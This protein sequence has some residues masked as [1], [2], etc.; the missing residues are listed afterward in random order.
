M[1]RSRGL[2]S[3]AALFATAG[4]VMAACGDDD[5]GEEATPTTEEGAGGS[6]TTEGDEGGEA[7]APTGTPITIGVVFS[8]T[9]RT[10]VTY[11]ASG[12]VAEAWA[13]WVNAE[14]G[15]VNGHPVEIA[16]VDGL[17]TGEGAAA[18]G[19]EVVE[20]AGAV[21]V[22]INDSTAENALSQ[23]LESQGVPYIGGSNNGRPADSSPTH[24]PNLYFHQGTSVP[25]SSASTLLVAAE[26]GGTTLAAAVCS[27]VPTCA[28]A[29]GL[30]EQLAPELGLEYV[31]LVTVGAAD[32]SY[33][34][35]CL[36]LIGDGADVI[37]LT[38]ASATVTSLVDECNAQ[39]FEG[40][41][42]LP[43]QSFEYSQ[44]IEIEDLRAA[45]NFPWFPWYADA[46]PVQQFR[47]AMDDAGFDNYTGMD[48]TS[49]WT[50]LELFRKAMTD[51]GPAADAEVTSA[52]VIAAYHQIDGETLDGLL[53][54]PITYVEEGFQP[55]VNCF[56]P[57][58][59]EDGEL[60]TLESDLESGNGA[61]GD[62]KSICY[63]PAS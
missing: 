5:D 12:P 14:Q 58:L 2:R 54:Q 52:D 56:W 28:E 32:P 53:A 39:G 4:L 15:G 62:L 34:A 43:G 9:G 59:L 37:N 57:Y 3:A 26:A 40:L 29:G 38:I 35:P 1:T 11:D 16:A 33:T 45:G 25:P 23:Y 10:A 30:Y 18:A 63:E 47:D 60:T 20:S 7:A 61:E 55:V 36:Q 51:F 44:A 6:A 27:E 13:E 21:A 31:G 41:Y 22:V 46:E 8:E 48:A 42:S 50:A 49:T 19:R 24:W 17:S